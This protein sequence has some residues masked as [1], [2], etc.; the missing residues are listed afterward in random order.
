MLDEEVV[1]KNTR[2]GNERLLIVNVL[3]MFAL[4]AIFFGGTSD[5]ITGLFIA[6]G[7]LAPINVFVYSR[8]WIDATPHTWMRFLLA[9]SPYIIAFIITVV[10]LSHPALEHVQIGSREYLKLLKN[11]ETLLASAAPSF[12][13]AITPDLITLGCAAC[14]LSIYFITESRYIIRR[15]IFYCSL[16][17]ASIAVLGFLYDAI[18]AIKGFENMPSFG[19]GGFF[20]FP[21]ASWWSAFA[22]L[23]MGGALTVAVYSA[24]RFRFVTFFYSLRFLSLLSAVILFFSIMY[25][26]TPIER[27]L[28]M[29]FAAVACAVLTFDTIPTNKNL[30]RHWTSKYSR[31]RKNNFMS[32]A[33]VPCLVYAAAGLTAAA[34]SAFTIV[35]SA[36]NK[37]EM[38]IVNADNESGVTL[39]E[40]RALLVDSVDIIELKPVFG[41][42]TGSF[43]NVFA[44]YQSSDLGDCAWDS[45]HSEIVKKIIEN[46]FAGLALAA[47][48]P[49]IFFVM[50][51]MRFDFSAS[52]LV[53]LF[54]LGCFGVL[55]VIDCPLQCIAVQ[56]SF[57]VLMMSLFKWDC[58]KVR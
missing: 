8:A 15:I 40:R 50:W 55:A 32:S 42:G 19:E 16:I 22:L 37:D 49:F 27:V 34:V 4:P 5:F 20:I 25:C 43:S 7:I 12:L 10:G 54:A 53:L 24:Q 33:I 58:A 28:A 3:L 38:L 2:H 17:A 14:G 21:I 35:D 18:L 13:S 39:A 48:T 1:N 29:W 26:G 51:L 31:K 44:F 45:P 36:N 30:S 57:W 41:W 46:G 11:G 52:G 9:L 23:W 6:L 56:I 47:I